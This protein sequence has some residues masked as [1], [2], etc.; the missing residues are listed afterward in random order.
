MI[1]RESIY[2]GLFQAWAPLLGL[3]F[4]TLSR[5]LDNFTNVDSYIQ[6]ALYQLQAGEKIMPQRGLPSKLQLQVE[7]FVYARSEDSTIPPSS[8]LN[9]LV[10]AVLL[11]T[12]PPAGK[13]VQTFGIQDVQ[14]IWVEGEIKIAE[15]V[16]ENQVIAVIPVNILIV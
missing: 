7:L 11:L 14:H 8:V 13:D 1:D 6:P 16:L 5:R 2:E 10:D 3:G 15:G 12:L 9:P 4:R